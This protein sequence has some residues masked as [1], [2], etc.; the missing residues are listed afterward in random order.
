VKCRRGPGAETGEYLVRK[1]IK[2][3][4]GLL[5]SACG[6]SAARLRLYLGE[7]GPGGPGLEI[8][9]GV[10]AD[11]SAELALRESASTAGGFGVWRMDG[12]GYGNEWRLERR[13]AGMSVS[14]DLELNE[15]TPSFLPRRISAAGELLGLLEHLLPLAD[16]LAPGHGGCGAAAGGGRPFDPPIAGISPSIVSLREDIRK[17]A[18]GRIHVLICGESGTGKELVAR[19]IHSLGPRRAGPFIAVNCLEMPAGLLQ[20]ELFGSARGAYTGADRD[21]EGLIEAAGG[22]T[23]FLD[24][25]GEL[26]VHLQAAL[27]RVLQER[28]IRRLGEGRSRKVD[29]RFVFAT[30][31]DLEGLVRAGR[32]R[33][34]LYFRLSAVRLHIPP[35]RERSEDVPVLTA[36]FLRESSLQLSGRPVSMTAGALSRLIGYRW[37]G[38]VRELRN[39]IE[40][41]LTMN[42][43]S[44]RITASMLG[45]PEGRGSILPVTDSGLEAGTMPEAVMRLE[46]RMIVDALEGFGGNRTRTAKALGIT[47][48]G[49]LK[50]LKRMNIDPDRHRDP[51]KTVISEAPPSL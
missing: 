12:S 30:N 34:D 41:V 49:L 21:R 10:P 20:G 8:C 40:R 18:A 35:L 42:P 31:R 48:Q 36:R 6:A 4:L 38:N 27:L 19:N 28:E 17:V 3:C 39:E 13:L 2:E 25:I 47:R 43:G 32:F 5:C 45:I 14:L 22:G 7:P 37:P 29:V 50:K 16:V 9:G 1:A 46:R 33:E 23:F 51:V 11:Q 24:E 26:P 15:M 44:V